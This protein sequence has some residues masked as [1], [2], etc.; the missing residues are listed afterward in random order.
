MRFISSFHDPTQQER[1]KT[2]YD[3][4]FDEMDKE[5]HEKHKAEIKRL[6]KL[7]MEFEDKWHKYLVEQ[8]FDLKSSSDE[9]P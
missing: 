7:E 2:M 9:V 1:L 6:Q 3:V 5:E 4:E 8:Q